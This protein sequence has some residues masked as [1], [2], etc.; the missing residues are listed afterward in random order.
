RAI[1]DPLAASDWE[2]Y[3]TEGAQRTNLRDGEVFYRLNLRANRNVPA[4]AAKELIITSALLHGDGYALV[5]R[6]NSGRVIGWDPL[7]SSRM[8]KS[9]RNDPSAIGGGTIVYEYIA[10]TGAI[11]EV[12]DTD[13]IHL[14][15]PSVASIFGGDSILA[16]AT[17]AI[18][19]AAAQEKFGNVYF[20]NGAH[21][22]GYLQLKG[23]LKTQAD[24]D[25][26]KADW[27]A[28]T[29]G[30]HKVGETAVLEDGAEFHSLTPDAERVQ[31]V[32][33][34]AFQVE[35]IARYFGVPLVKL[36]V[37]EAA[38]GYGSNLST[39]NEQ[40]SRDTLTPWAKRI[41]QEFGFKLLPQR[42]P[43]A[44]ISVDLRWT[45]RGDAE[46]R[47]RV[48]QMDV[49]SGVIT[50][51]EAR[52]EEGLSALPGGVGAIVTVAAG[53]MELTRENLAPKPPAPPP[54]PPQPEPEDQ[55]D[56]G[57][58]EVEVENLVRAG[59]VLALDNHAKRWRARTRDVPED[60]VHA[61]REELRARLAH[62]LGAF[63]ERI[64]D[65]QFAALATQVEAGFEPAKAADHVLAREAA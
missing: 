48:R 17:V 63:G 39:L 59:V 50:R 29:A 27:N 9:W 23:R 10:E 28:K 21:L 64:T 12:P 51:D 40:F 2:V 52:A 62:D 49:Q 6:D 3:V 53:L 5:L 32:A 37:K 58:P 54:G 26:L 43:W 36:M 47:A 20:A 60:K 41:A 8:R 44:E 42:S 25:R 45:T 18:A 14:R 19:T 35:E 4:I 11:Y 24:V 16:R 22:G 31:L 57:P 55:A 56:K 46:S 7:D 13:V 15:G 30:L 61:A 1:V 34:R 33:P 65:E 38:S